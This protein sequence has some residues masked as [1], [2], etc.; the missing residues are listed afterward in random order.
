MTSWLILK[1]GVVGAEASLAA[2]IAAQA[3]RSKT[4]PKLLQ[5]RASLID[6]A[7]ALR[8]VSTAN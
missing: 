6:N 8:Y 2:A 3:W 5:I 7:R 1:A 4:T